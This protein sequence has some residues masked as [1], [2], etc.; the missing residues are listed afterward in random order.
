MKPLSCRPQSHSLACRRAWRATAL[1]ALACAASS[2]T[3]H[4]SAYVQADRLWAH[5]VVPF[6]WDKALPEGNRQ[7]VLA[8]MNIWIDVASVSFVSRTD[9][10][11][12]V[13]IQNAAGDNGSSSPTIGRGGGKQI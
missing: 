2:P 4:A 3:A 13:H 9:E 8:A 5:G 6:V 10:P 12:Y 7:R 1:F 11:D